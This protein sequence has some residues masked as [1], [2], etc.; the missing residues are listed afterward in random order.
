M[1]SHVSFVQPVNVPAGPNATK[2]FLPPTLTW[3]R[4]EPAPQSSS[5]TLNS[6]DSS[7]IWP[8][9]RPVG[10]GTVTPLKSSVVE[11]LPVFAT[12]VATPSVTVAPPNVVE[13]S[14]AN[15]GAVAASANAATAA[16]RNFLM[17]ESPSMKR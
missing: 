13:P 17:L 10:T 2:T 14:A 15:A 8:N 12:S 6:A 7:V 16:S 4:G 11:A 3:N 5:V 9:V 1:V